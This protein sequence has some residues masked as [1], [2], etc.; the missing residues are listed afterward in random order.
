MVCSRL[1]C[2]FQTEAIAF[3]SLRTRGRVYGVLGLV[4]GLP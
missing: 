4:S 3:L 2:A 1:T